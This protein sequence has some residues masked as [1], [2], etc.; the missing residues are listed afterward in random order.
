MDPAEVLMSP[1]FGAFGGLEVNQTSALRGLEAQKRLGEIAMQPAEQKLKES[2][3]RF[4]TAEAQA[5][6]NEAAAQRGMAELMAKQNPAGSTDPL[7]ILGQMSSVAGAA[8]SKGYVKP[9]ME[10]LNKALTGFQHV[11]TASAANASAALRAAHATTTYLDQIGGLASSAVDQQSYD[12]AKQAFMS[13]PNL[14]AMA[15]QRGIDLSRLP[16]DYYT[17]KPLMDSLVTRTQKAK[18][19]IAAKERKRV[20]DAKIVQLG[21]QAGA[22]SAAAE[23]SRAR[24]K[25]SKLRADDIE[26]NGGDTSNNARAARESAIAARKAAREAADRRDAATEAH[27]AAINAAR[28]PVPDPAAIKNPAL[29]KVGQTYS[30]PKGPLTW[31]GQGWVKPGGGG[32]TPAAR[33][34]TAAEVADE[35]DDADADD[36]E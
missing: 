17:A 9:G 25:V 21:A 8:I 14:V 32:T 31:T 35:E 12:I 5:K 28:F 3:A 4:Y 1:N 10:M 13:D 2:H 27:R 36:S 19:I 33:A 23:A 22:S 34:P 18:D 7:E 16:Q 15:K 26:K 11:A 20:D 30:T 6:E 29:L 24:A